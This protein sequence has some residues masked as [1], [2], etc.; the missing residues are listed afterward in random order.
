M[1]LVLKAEVRRVTGKT[2]HAIGTLVDG[3]PVPVAQLTQPA[4]VGISPEDNGYYLLHFD[5]EGLCLTDTWHESL[6]RAKAQA[7]FEFEIEERDW[8][9]T[10]EEVWR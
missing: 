2:K 3:N 5:A 8:R 10:D 7:R 1:K 4:W 9:V 6:E